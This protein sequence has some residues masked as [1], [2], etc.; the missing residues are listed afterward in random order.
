MEK[1]GCAIFDDEVDYNEGDN[2]ERDS[3]EGKNY[4]KTVVKKN[5]TLKKPSGCLS[6]CTLVL[7]VSF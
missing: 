6:G 2:S 4:G 1:G 7:I 3:N 5:K